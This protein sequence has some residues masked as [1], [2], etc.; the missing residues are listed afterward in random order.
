[1][2]GARWTRAGSL[3]QTLGAREEKAKGFKIWTNV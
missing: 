1:M 2:D 3:F